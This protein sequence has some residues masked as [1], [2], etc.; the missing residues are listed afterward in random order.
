M[1]APFTER[2]NARFRGIVV[3][4]LLAPPTVLAAL[5]GWVRTPYVLGEV[6]PLEQPVEFDHRHHVVDDGL[7][8]RYCHTT[9]ETEASAGYPS[10]E[11]C[12]NCHNQIWN[13]TPVLEPVRTS[14][15]RDVPLAW[16]RVHR[17]PD[18]VFF[19]HAIHVSKGIG[20]ETCHGR[21]DR[22]AR[23]YQVAPLTMA[24]CLDCHRNPVANLRPPDEITT[25][26]WVPGPDAPAPAALGELYDV[27]T[28]TDCTACHR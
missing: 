6:Q 28:P 26:G 1:T 21:V 5:W 25:M 20:C 18:F 23:V 24:W 17:L 11:L 16:A 15:F 27:R 19:H 8:C 22:M 10:S 13:E 14:F 9:V 3:L 2:S 7:D 4:A 12:M